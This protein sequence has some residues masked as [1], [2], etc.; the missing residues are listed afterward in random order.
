MNCPRVVLDTN[1]YVSALVYSGRLTRLRTAWEGG[2][3]VP[4]MC[5]ETIVEFVDILS[6]SKFELEREHVNELLSNLLYFA[7]MFV[8]S[9][10]LA[11]VEGL[12]DPKGIAF[13]NLAREAKADYLVSGDKDLLDLKGTL[14]GVTIVPPGE[15]LAKI[16]GEF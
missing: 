4:L 5:R 9:D 6:R 10:P 15:F 3:F 13:V 7:E 12:R 2:V 1:C 16:L 8:L 11:P 14:P